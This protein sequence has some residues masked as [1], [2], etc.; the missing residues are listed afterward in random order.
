VNILKKFFV[1]C[2]IGILS[3]IAATDASAQQVNQVSESQ[4]ASNQFELV[5]EENLTE[6]EKVFVDYAKMY[7]G[8]H[9][10]GSIYVI[11]LGEQ[12]N[13]G[14]GLKL[15]QQI[16]TWEQFHLYVKKIVPEEGK[17]YPQVISYPYMVGK[18]HLPPYTTISVLDPDT[19]KPLFNNQRKSLDFLEKRITTN[20]WKEWFVYLDSPVTNSLSKDNRITL[21][22]LGD[23]RSLH[24]IQL[25]RDKANKKIVKVKPLVEYENGCTYL[26]NIEDKRNGE[27][28][29]LPFEVKGPSNTV[30]LEYDFTDG[31]KGWTGG[32]SDLPI[33]Y[34]T[35][36]FALEFGHK[37]IPLNEETLKKG[38][39][40]SG[41]NRSDDLFMYAKTKIGK[42]HGLL[43]NQWYLLIMEIA[44]Y[45]NTD[46]GLAG[47]GGSPGEG[48]YVKAGAS[49]VEPKSVYVN[50]DL[51]MNIDKG[52]QSS[53]G[54]NAV[55]IGNV[56]K[57]VA[58][59][60]KYE[61]KKLKTQQPILVRTN[62][63][64]E[65]WAL[66][67]TDSAFEGKTTL[68][69]TSVKISLEKK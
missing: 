21:E 32:F 20:K 68:Y 62:N 43:P 16:Q 26:L 4:A 29:I 34:D 12:P 48:V 37:R 57:E 31:L 1:P 25:I 50:G 38:L 65:L 36:D 42:E 47:A 58:S 18:L 35:E 54:R 60:Q 40:L 61:L 64:G 11:S 27:R 19:K 10:F 3:I 14:F 30:Q 59:Q 22:K 13:P 46:P 33:K 41:M 39:T 52:E 49:T 44:F 24:P 45:T 51:R 17:E 69:Y 8:I 15:E 9:R 66:F 23:E 7:E 67:G 28:T 6:L 63:Q 55:V 53:S 56:A 2:L 5:N